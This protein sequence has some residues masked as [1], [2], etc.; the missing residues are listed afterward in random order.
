[1]EII[2]FVMVGNVSIISFFVAV[3]GIIV[4]LFTLCNVSL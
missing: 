4:T 3:R 1:M 2:S